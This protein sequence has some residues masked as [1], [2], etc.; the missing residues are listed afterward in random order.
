MTRRSGFE[1]LMEP[2]YIGRI[3]TRNRIIKTASGTGLLD[4]DGTVGEAIIAHY[5][6]LAK[7][8]VGLIIFE[9]CTV[10][11]PRGS[12][13][14]GLVGAR[15]HDDQL[16]P[17]Y[18]ELT[19]VVH[20]HGCPIFI[21]LY[22][23]GPWFIPGEGIVDA[24]DRI[25]VSVLT[26]DDFPSRELSNLS[27]RELS[28]GKARELSIADI[29][30]LINTFA[31]AAE[32]AQKAGFDGVELNSS[33][34]HLLNSFLSRFWNRRQDAYGCGSPENRARFLCNVI[35]EI[36]KRCGQDFAV[37]TLINGAEYGLKNGIT[38]EE[39][40]RTAQLLQEA[41][42]DAIHVRT[43]GYGNLSD[44]LHSDRFFY[45]E[46]PRELIV[47]GL[48]Y[49]RKGRGMWVPLGAAIKKMV[50]I[51][52]FVAGRLDPELGEEILRQGKLDFIGM[53][54]RL[55]AD[56]ELP[57]KV[58]EGR[59]EDI[60]PCS[61]CLYCWHEKAC[62][63]RPIRCRINAAL[64]REREY[65]IKPVEKKK[66]VLIAGSGPAGMEAARVA[67]LRGHEVILYEKWYKLGGL[68]PL[69]AIVKDLE[70]ESILDTIHYFKTQMTKLGVKIRLEKEVNFS[71]IKKINP[72]V[73]ILA[74]GGVSVIPEIPGINNR[75]V[76]SSDQLHGKLK[77]ALRLLGP[78]A[79][80]GLTK[81]WMPIGKRVVIIG[82]ALAGCQLAEFLVKRGRKVT[83]VDTAKKLGE[84]LLSNDP[85]R[86][87]KW[88]DQK[89]MTMMAEV[90]YEEIT[91][92]GLV[93]TTKEGERRTL[94]ADTI[95]TAL[96]LL[97]TA[98]L[99]KS[100]EG[101]VPEVYQ[102]GD[103]RE[104]GFIHNAIADGSRIARMI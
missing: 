39:A 86:L 84:G 29:G 33:H 12:N 14:P 54:R 79:I 7:G 20:K 58:A 53:T 65:E 101:K 85:T 8:G 15:I 102:I 100:L 3:H 88:L 17:G 77:L 95:M 52:V 2:G 32:R 89:G 64:G 71:E 22:H 76:L 91:D 75:K 42:A 34:F 10:E 5:E 63:N 19:K 48:D 47:E 74:T 57:N 61:G 25:A 68:L 31:N 50:S 73:V 26:D 43:E 66:K 46:L 96:P 28:I 6:A 72:D 38:L 36:K 37:D 44:M 97:P 93:I 45:P 35:R 81:L 80:E 23:S 9:F 18:R 55:L 62:N 27:H 69:A 90:K 67:A 78:K 1:K 30:E 103:C 98:D 11:W 21:Q 41:G 87:F 94:E 59:L 92:K 49:S 82:G 99:L 60:A 56:P 24:G 51:P 104:S 70:F 13:R 4:K 83:I 16:I 40:K